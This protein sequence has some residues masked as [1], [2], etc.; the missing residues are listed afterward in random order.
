MAEQ[1][2]NGADIGASFEQMY[3]ERM[4]TMPDAA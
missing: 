1:E 4:A 3:G 2:L